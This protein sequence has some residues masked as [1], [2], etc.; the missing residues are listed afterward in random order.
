[1][2]F[3]QYHC[4]DWT[5]ATVTTTYGGTPSTVNKLLLR[6]PPGNNIL[7]APSLCLDEDAC[8]PVDYWRLTTYWKRMAHYEIVEHTADIALRA[9][10]E[11]LEG[12]FAMAAR[13]MFEIIAGTEVIEGSVERLIELESIDTEGLLVGFLSH[14][15]YL[16]EVNGE[17]YAT[18]EVSLEGDTKMTARIRGEAF[19]EE[20]HANGLEV[21]GVSYHMLETSKSKAGSEAYVQVLFDV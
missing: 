4:L 6:Q 7:P 5:V 18:C 1:M 20:R 16:S 2:K 3:S 9:Y 12:A 8:R 10:G 21:K 11:N 14:L 17:L 19:D 15:L 13:G